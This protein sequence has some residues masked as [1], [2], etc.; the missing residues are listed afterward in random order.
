MSFAYVDLVPELPPVDE[1]V[2]CLAQLVARGYR[3]VR[4]ITS[5]YA[6]RNVNG[7]WVARAAFGASWE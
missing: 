4:G 1:I 3:A 5:R 6:R 2:R 7:D